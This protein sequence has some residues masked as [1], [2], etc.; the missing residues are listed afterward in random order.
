MTSF[1]SAG[2]TPIGSDMP[3]FYEFFAGGGMARAGLGAG[4]TCLFAND[5]DHKKGL[6]YQ[7]NWGKGGELLVGDVGKVTASEL[8]RICRP[9]LGLF[10]LPGFVFGGG[11][12]RA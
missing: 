1:S 3:N 11:R 5:F 9:G 10:S 7:A 8:A 2:K 6:A 4:W 12:R